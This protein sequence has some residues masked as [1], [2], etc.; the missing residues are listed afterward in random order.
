MLVNYLN[1][2]NSLQNKSQ[3]RPPTKEDDPVACVPYLQSLY[4]WWFPSELNTSRSVGCLWRHAVFGHYG[5]TEISSEVGVRGWNYVC[6]CPVRAHW[7]VLNG[8]EVMVFEESEVSRPGSRQRYYNASSFAGK[9]FW[10]SLF[11][12]DNCVPL[13]YLFSL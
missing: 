5:T 10:N 11:F 2:Y 7:Q 9:S 13:K 8:K 12:G 4:K 1:W 6:M 3:K